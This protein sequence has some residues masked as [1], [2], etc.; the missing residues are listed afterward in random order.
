MSDTSDRISEGG[1]GRALFLYAASPHRWL[2]LPHSL[3]S[4][5]S[6]AFKMAAGFS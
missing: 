5:T 2:E 3:E 6:G 4:Q 1:D